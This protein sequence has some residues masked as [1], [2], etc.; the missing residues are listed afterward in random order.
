MRTTATSTRPVVALAVDAVLVLGFCVAGRI[1]HASGI[2]GDIPGLLHTVW[3]F[4]TALLLAHLVVALAHASS[5]RLPA[6]VAIW[7]VTVIGGLL[8]R[9]VSGQG[10]AVPFVLVTAATLALLLLGWR[11]VVLLVTRAATG[12]SGS[13]AAR[14]R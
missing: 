9:V 2:L 10:T 12:A 4:V 6:G 7:L 11:A 1:S 8:L 14:I 3:P 13:G 5:V